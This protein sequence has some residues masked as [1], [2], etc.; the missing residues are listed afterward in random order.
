MN[1][2]EFCSFSP[3]FMPHS[4]QSRVTRAKGGA[5]TSAMVFHPEPLIARTPVVGN[6][7]DVMGQS[8]TL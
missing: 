5:A 6:N 3:F 4:E 1:K 2:P 7:E 8:A